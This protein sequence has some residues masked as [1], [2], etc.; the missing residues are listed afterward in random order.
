METAERS[1][2]NEEQDV[3]A[4]LELLTSAAPGNRV[5]LIGDE[6]GGGRM[7]AAHLWPGLGGNDLPDITVHNPVHSAAWS[8]WK[9]TL[10]YP[11]SFFDVILCDHVAS[12]SDLYSDSLAD[13]SRITSPG[14]LLLIID[15]L[16]PGTRLRGKKARQIREA[17]SYINAWTRL[18]CPDHQR[19]LD[20]ET[21]Q[22]YLVDNSWTLL[23]WLTHRVA[24]DFDTWC[25]RQ[26]LDALDRI[27]LRA[28]LVQAPEKVSGFLTPLDTGDR[29][30]FY[31]TEGFILAA[32]P[33]ETL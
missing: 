9:S 6:D 2:T 5:L 10:P 21:W 22:Q 1:G 15:N 16:I 29:M 18:W 31:L 25:A 7:L 24:I 28:M 8:P 14:G 17:G 12:K 4:V 26:P 20:L 33:S 30:S 19:Y 3:T 11:S 13:L 32:K 23:S 27:R